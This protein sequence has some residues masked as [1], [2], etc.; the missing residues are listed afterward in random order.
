VEVEFPRGRFDFDLLF[1]IVAEAK[2]S[3]LRR[4]QRCTAGTSTTSAYQ[5]IR[6]LKA[7]DRAVAQCRRGS[8]DGRFRRHEAKQV[9]APQPLSVDETSEQE[10]AASWRL[11]KER[12]GWGGG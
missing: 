4:S 3:E 10:E 2:R 12:R 8:R 11:R 6:S 5:S 9:P 7:Q 1:P